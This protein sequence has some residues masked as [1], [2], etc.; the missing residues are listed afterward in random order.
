MKIDIVIPTLNRRDKLQTCINSIFRSAKSEDIALY[1]YFGTQSELEFFKVQLNNVPN[2][3]I[4]YLPEYKV[5]T[6]WNNYLSEMKADALCYLNDDVELYEDTLE[7][8]MEDYQREFPNMDG[9]LGLNQVNIKDP[10]K[11][12]SAFGVIGTKYADRYPNRQVWCPDYFRFYG[13]WELWKRAKDIGKFYF[14]EVARINH[15]HPCTNKALVDATHDAV[16]T[17]LRQDK[18][19]F[20]RRQSM[21]LL[22]GK[23]FKL[24]NM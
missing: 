18:L 23:D 24:I 1:L 20:Q 3:Y 15:Y 9:V 12:E 11:V 5:P 16:R 13:D 10:H 17:Y 22:W 4:R 8:I 19:T 14:S 6:F 7:V 21:D 2:V